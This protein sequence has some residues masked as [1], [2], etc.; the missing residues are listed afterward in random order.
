MATRTKLTL[1][2]CLLV[3]VFALSA[4]ALAQDAGND[5]PALHVLSCDG[6]C[7]DFTPARPLAHD[8]PPAF[9]TYQ[10]TVAALV[11]AQYVIGV[12]GKVRT[13]DLLQVQ[14][15]RSFADRTLDA[16]HKWTFEP[17]RL[18]GLPIESVMQYNVT[19]DGPVRGAHARQFVIDAYNR[20]GGLIK[21][22][23]D[24]EAVAALNGAGKLSDLNFYER[25]MMAFPLAMLAF[26]RQDYLETRR[27]VGLAEE[28]GK[29]SLD[30]VTERGLWEL[31]IESDLMLGD[32]VDA[33][34][35]YDHLVHNRN[36][37]LEAPAVKLLAKANSSAGAMPVLAATGKIPSRDEG[38][39]YTFAL[40]R[41]TFAFQ[42][43]S[44]SLDSFRLVCNPR[45]MESK[46][47]DTAQWKV[48]KSWGSCVLLVRGAP[49]STFRIL[50]TAS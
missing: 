29:G 6:K 40:Y 10:W 31:Q 18:N 2:A 27:I 37:D 13:V 5:L 33:N 12:D 48:P 14:G 32:M 50:Q 41:N 23:K 26:K 46:I 17:A 7:A 36:F 21:D 44:G 39:V 34:R 25:S 1:S 35:A 45:I 22:G 28:M 30:P 15:P 16:I 43:L 19:Y 47:A 24:S 49:G 20:A 9:G 38:D 42:T 8:P 3:S 4:L 11:M